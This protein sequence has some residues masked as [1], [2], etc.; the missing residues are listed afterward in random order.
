MVAGATGID[1]FLMVV[2]ADD[3]VM[4]QTREHAAVLAA[5]GVRDGVVAITKSDVADPEA[6]ALEA[7]ELFPS[8]SV[9]RCSSR[10]GEGVADVLAAL[11]DVVGHVTGRGG[12]AGSPLLHVDR[13]FTI[14]GAGTV[15]TGTLWSGSIGRGDELTLL[16]AGRSVRV[17]G[18][19]VHDEAVDRAGA[20]QRV[21]VNLV[22]VEVRDVA[23]GDVLAT[24]A[25]E[26]AYVVDAALDLRD[27]EHGQR[28]HVHHG[29][30]E[31]PARLAQLG[32]RFWQLRLEQPLIV[33]RGDH[34][35]VRS[36]APPDTLGGGVALDPQAKKHGPSRDAL[37]RLT[38]LERGEDDVPPVKQK[39]SDPPDDLPPVKQKGSDPICFTEE[40]IALEE[41]LRSAGHEPP[42]EADL[43]AEA[44]HLPVLLE[45]GR[46]VRV[47]PRLWSHP[48][49]VA[50]VAGRVRSLVERE[51]PIRLAR[52]GDDLGT[53]RKYAQAW[54]GHLDAARVTRRLPDE[55]RILRRRTA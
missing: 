29:T 20:G 45:A 48:D 37:A 36:V 43:G 52:R 3:G 38:R 51:G 55:S 11:A 39:G 14:K 34:V 4:P 22:G 8:A 12:D 1:L 53:S 41:R 25:L 6:A 32:G 19:Q 27:A 2:A 47:G 33:R 42:L 54:L 40:Q 9:V 18:V 28:V 10:T 30:R 46:A 13:A 15:V 24:T 5:L 35:V 21:A 17:R 16:P 44:A 50:E 31:A 26:P 23:R 49:A 7:A